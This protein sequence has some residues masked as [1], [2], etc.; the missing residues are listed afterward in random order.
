MKK[1]QILTRLYGVT[2]MI[3]LR[4]NILKAR[5]VTHQ[6]YDVT[7]RMVYAVT[8]LLWKDEASESALQHHGFH[9]ISFDYRVTLGF[10]SIT[11]GLDPVYPVIRLPIERGISSGT[12]DLLEKEF[13][14]KYCSPFKTAKKLEEI[15]NFKQEIDVVSCLGKIQSSSLQMSA[16]RFE[17]PT[18]G[19]L[20]EK[21]GSPY[22]T[23][24]TVCMIENPR[25]VHKLKARED[26]GDMDVSWDITVKDVER[27]RKF[28]TPTIHTLTNT[29]PIVKP[30]MSLGPVHDKEEIVKDEKHDYDIPLHDGV[31]QPLMP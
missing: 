11:G 28:L 15:R 29:E 21:I 7:T 13:I 24:K 26:E 31:M 17:L 18:E 20:K 27:L 12:R 8:L 25:E 14:W 30:Y 16:V 3:V 23:R 6:D 10:G 1:T 19:N 2:P 9:W 22:R 5:H 4:R